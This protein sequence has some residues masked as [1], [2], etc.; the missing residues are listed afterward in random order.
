MLVFSEGK[1]L[2]VS[3]LRML[4]AQAHRLVL[5]THF[6]LPLQSSCTNSWM[7]P[8]CRNS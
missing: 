1:C 5:I 2:V 7:P 3:G 8:S 4:V 6:S